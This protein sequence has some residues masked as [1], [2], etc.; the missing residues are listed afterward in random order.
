MKIWKSIHFQSLMTRKQVNKVSRIGKTV[1]EFLY[2]ILIK[3]A[4]DSKAPRKSWRRRSSY[5]DVLLLNP[6]FQIISGGAPRSRQ[7]T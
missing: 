3:Q 4:S 1:L 7:L 5:K 6:Y 2:Q